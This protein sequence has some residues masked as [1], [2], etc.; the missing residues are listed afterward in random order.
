MHQLIYE[1]NAM[2]AERDEASPSVVGL[3]LE[4]QR[5]SLGE[6]HLL[7]PMQWVIAPGGDPLKYLE[8]PSIFGHWGDWGWLLGMFIWVSCRGSEMVPV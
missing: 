7:V 3:H 1:R 8:P 2:Q 5:K 4:D 6:T